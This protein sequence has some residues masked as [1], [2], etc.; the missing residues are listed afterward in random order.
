VETLTSR[1]SISLSA[2]DWSTPGTAVEDV[3]KAVAELES[4]AIPR[5][6]VLPLH[7]RRYSQLVRY[8]ERAGVMELNRVKALMD[9]VVPIPHVPE[10]QVIVFSANPSVTDI[11]V[12]SDVEVTPVGENARGEYEFR[13]WELVLP[14]VKDPRGVVVLS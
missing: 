5:P 1:A 3:A 7:P 12:A 6:Y 2:G 11:L 9:E 10:G 8:T 13:V 4:N 14:R